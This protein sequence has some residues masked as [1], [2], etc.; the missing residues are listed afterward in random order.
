MDS[1]GAD[2]MSLKPVPVEGAVPE[3][4]GGR[5]VVGGDNNRLARFYEMLQ[6][7]V[8]KRLQP[9]AVKRLP[10]QEVAHQVSDIVME[11]LDLEPDA[12]DLLEQRSLVATLVND[13]VTYGRPFRVWLRLNKEEPIELD[14]IV[15]EEVRRHRRLR[16][17][18]ADANCRDVL[19]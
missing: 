12:P 18:L 19:V 13:L 4:A 14:K 9:E 6:P 17:R 15:L 8:K 3:S 16:E 10:R 5:D 2:K 1:S 11:V 7:M